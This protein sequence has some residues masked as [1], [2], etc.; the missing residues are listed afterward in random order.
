VY[1]SL[2]NPQSPVAVSQPSDSLICVWYYCA[3]SDKSQELM[4]QVVTGKSKKDKNA[5]RV[6]PQ[7]TKKA[8]EKISDQVAQVFAD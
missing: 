1:P 8:K 4:G 3:G 2:V 7:S 6:V 5:A